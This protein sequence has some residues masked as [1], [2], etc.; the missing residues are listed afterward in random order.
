MSDMRPSTREWLLARSHVHTDFDAA[1]L[2]AG[3]VPAPDAAAVE[4]TQLVPAGREQDHLRVVI[5]LRGAGR[6]NGRRH[7]KPPREANH[8]PPIPSMTAAT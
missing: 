4:V 7:R 6:G 2:V 1:T 5:G 8:R 3:S